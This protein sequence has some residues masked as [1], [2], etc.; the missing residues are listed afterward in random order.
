MWPFSLLRMKRSGFGRGRGL[1]GGR[2][3]IAMWRVIAAT[4]GALGCAENVRLKV[5]PRA[6]AGGIQ[7][8]VAVAGFPS[9]HWN[10]VPP[11]RPEPRI[12]TVTTGAPGAVAASP[13]LTCFPATASIRVPSAGVGAAHAA[14]G[15]AAGLAPDQGTADAEA[16]SARQSTAAPERKTRKLDRMKRATVDDM[17]REGRGETRQPACLFDR[18]GCPDAHESIKSADIVIRQSDAAV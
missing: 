12:A 7:F 8:S 14:P 1:G 4:P 13:T 17:S 10:A 9:C 16:G 18:D 3:A 5:F 15:T 6:V 2:T 11:G